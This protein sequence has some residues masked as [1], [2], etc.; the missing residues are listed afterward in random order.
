MAQLEIPGIDA[1][2]DPD[3]SPAALPRSRQ[4]IKR[5][6]TTQ[7]QLIKP[8]AKPRSEYLPPVEPPR[9]GVRNRIC[10]GFDESKPGWV[11]GEPVTKHGGYYCERCLS[12]H[13]YDDAYWKAQVM[14]LWRGDLHGKPLS[15]AVR[16]GRSYL[17]VV[18]HLV[19]IGWLVNG[20]RADCIY[21]IHEDDLGGIEEY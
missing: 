11:C 16:V 5:I 6:D 1:A 13:D 8:E 15:I 21:M 19:A 10:Y 3:E 17:E 9:P 4:R 7:M 18:R 14:D 20:S 12:Q 2:G